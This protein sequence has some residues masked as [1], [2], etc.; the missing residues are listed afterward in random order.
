[1][2][3]RSAPRSRLVRPFASSRARISCDNHASASVWSLAPAISNVLYFE[4]S[5]PG[6]DRT[7][8]VSDAAQERNNAQNGAARSAREAFN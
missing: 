1:M 4:K 3:S 5:A 7:L 2:T 8:V 6:S